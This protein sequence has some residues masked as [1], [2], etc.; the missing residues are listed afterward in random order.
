MNDFEAAADKMHAQKI[1]QPA[2]FFDRQN[3]CAGVE[4]RSGKR[5]QAGANFQHK[6]RGG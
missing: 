5:A 6:I 1:R 3:L 2:I 4:R